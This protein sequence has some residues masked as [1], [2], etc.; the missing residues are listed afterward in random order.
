MS[1]LLYNAFITL[2]ISLFPYIASTTE[3]INNYYSNK[4]LDEIMLV[5]RGFETYLMR[6]RPSFTRDIHIFYK[7]R[8]QLM[9]YIDNLIIIQ[10][11]KM[12]NIDNFFNNIVLFSSEY[13]PYQILNTTY[14]GTERGF[15]SRW[16]VNAEKYKRK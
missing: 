12:E 8:F 9:G 6:T 1:H 4:T 14:E 2:I 11:P 16:A 7:A 3:D 15:L 5:I 10:D 13:S